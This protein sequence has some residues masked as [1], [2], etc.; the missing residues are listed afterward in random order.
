LKQNLLVV[1]GLCLCLCLLPKWGLA[2]ESGD[3]SVGFSLGTQ[4]AGI[5][6][7]YFVS[8]DAAVEAYGFGPRFLGLGV[9]LHPF[10][11]REGFLVASITRVSGRG[12]PFIAR[13]HS[14]KRAPKARYSLNSGG[15]F[16]FGHLSRRNNEFQGMS[17]DTFFLALGPTLRLGNVP[18]REAAIESGQR[19]RLS[20]FYQL[21]IKARYD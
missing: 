11:E 17:N 9:V 21:G 10:D 16:E 1:A 20:L 5:F 18:P 14:D 13:T 8:D 4:R 2:Q 7:Q 12:I 3:Y 6:V 19:R 15:G